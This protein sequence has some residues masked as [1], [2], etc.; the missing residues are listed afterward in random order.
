MKLTY[1]G[2]SYDYTPNPTPEFG[3]TYATGTYRGVATSFQALAEIPAQPHNSLTWRGV[4]YET[5]HAAVAA[6]VAEVVDSI[7]AVA[8]ATET[9]ASTGVVDRARQ[10]FIQ[11]H[12]RL[13]RREQGMMVRLAKE[14]GMSVEDA[15]HYESHVQGKVPH[16]FSG[17]DRSSTAMS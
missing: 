13:R 10:L 14:V 17:Y 1:R 9:P 16:D 15:G 2:V 8:I 7:P 12:Q 5:G 3:P 11:R 6:P 4:P